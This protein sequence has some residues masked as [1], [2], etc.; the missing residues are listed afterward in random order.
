MFTYSVFFR[1][2]FMNLNN[3][4]PYAG[5]HRSQSKSKVR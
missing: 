3:H 5:V 4:E 2:Y 1:V